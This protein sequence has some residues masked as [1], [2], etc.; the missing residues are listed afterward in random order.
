[1]HN[2]LLARAEMGM[3]ILSEAATALIICKW[4]LLIV[5]K[6][7][8]ASRNEVNLIGRYCLS[9]ST[10]KV[11]VATLTSKKKNTRPAVMQVMLLTN[12]TIMGVSKE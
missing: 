11:A 7:K 10:F 5:L 1:M 6:F 12:S 9:K 2:L 3:N 8:N 4:Y